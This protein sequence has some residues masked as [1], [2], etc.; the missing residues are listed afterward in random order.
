MA[1]ITKEYLIKSV[2]S[3][4]GIG[5]FISDTEKAKIVAKEL[6]LSLSSSAKVVEHSVT[7]SFNKAGQQVKSFSTTFEDFGRRT[8]ISFKTVAGVVQ[9]S[10]LSM[11]K[12]ISNFSAT[13]GQKVL[14]LNQ[15]LDGLAAKL[16]TL[17]SLNRTFSQTF[18]A[19]F[20]NASEIVQNQPEKLS[21]KTITFEGKQSLVPVQQL[22]TVVKTADGDFQK[23]N[24]TIVTLPNGVKQI[25]RSMSDVSAS[26]KKAAL[27]AETLTNASK[28]V[29]L[30]VTKVALS[31]EQAEKGARFFSSGMSRA[32]LLTDLSSKSINR[33]GSE[34]LRTTA[35]FNDNGKKV[36]TV[37]DSM[38]SSTKKVSQS[39][40]EFKEKT[41]A[42]GIDLG[43]LISRAAVTIPVWFA[44]RSAIMG[45]FTGIRDGITNLV[46]F[47]AALQ[48]VKR[49]LIGTPQQITSD[50]EKMRKVITEFSLQTGKPVEEIA[51]AVK[52]FATIGFNFEDSLQGGLD[53][54]KLSILL[55]G[56]AGQSAEAF[57]VALKL[58]MKTG[59]DAPPVQQQIAEAFALTAELAK[60]NKDKLSDLSQALGTVAGSASVAKLSFKETITLL[61]TLASAGKGGANGAT[62]LSSALSNLLTKLPQVSKSFGVQFIPGADSAFST[63]TKILDVATALSKTPAG[64]AQVFEKLGEVFGG[65]R[66][67]KLT[68]AL[69]AANAA[70]KENLKVTGDVARFN[71]G[72]TTVLDSESGQ[73]D[74][75]TNSVRETGKAFVTSLV[76][77]GNFKGALTS[78]NQIVTSL[79][80]TLKIIGGSFNAVFTSATGTLAGLG[81]LGASLTKANA[82]LEAMPALLSRVKVGLLALNAGTIA[83]LAIA[84]GVLVDKLSKGPDL[85]GLE[86]KFQATQVK[87]SSAL[88]GELPKVELEKFKVDFKN[89]KAILDVTTPIDIINKA[90]EK[91]LSSEE[92][93]AKVEAGETTLKANLALEAQLVEGATAKLEN[94]LAEL[95]ARLKAKGATDIELALLDV[96][97]LKSQ[98]EALNAE[99]IKDAQSKIRISTFE[100]ERSIQDALIKAVED[101]AKAEGASNLE[102]I[103][104]GIELEKSLGIERTGMELLTQQLSLQKALTEETK[105]T[106]EERLKE[107]SSLIKKTPVTGIAG[108]FKEQGLNNKEDAL[109]RRAEAKGISE[110]QINRILNPE[111]QISKGNTLLDELQRGLANPMTQ[112]MGSLEIAIS[113]LTQTILQQETRSLEVGVPRFGGGVRGTGNSLM[114]SES[115]KRRFDNQ[116]P[117]SVTVDVGGINVTVSG[118]GNADDIAQR[119]AKTVEEMISSNMVKPGTKANIAFTQVMHKA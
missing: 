87:L 66:G 14:T 94:D 3:S 107:L 4:I 112:S 114:L 76:G 40:G 34:F 47:D 51:S 15:P 59:K 22:S 44:L 6:G 26:F 55:F 74:I 110:E 79:N 86:D 77:A 81:I 64:E 65:Q 78:L 116:G 85:S 33:N 30:A 98:G 62:L 96:Q 119:V 49:N 56:E 108:F 32:A 102:A 50:F 63:L 9:A 115:D 39:F 58:L 109:R 19:S 88:R 70:L 11:S 24:Q 13:V 1:N 80:P 117:S 53:A 68:S 45:V 52:E 41:E 97:F 36:T 10:S 84:F 90:L 23:L 111:S 29:S 54:T 103:N 8:S 18:G 60:T 91:A 71:Q 72:V 104:R 37:F 101:G 105:K 38:G 16:T 20:K 82:L 67:V 21:Q 106:K 12:D 83:G 89:G 5:K 118:A 69:T 25:S 73:Y 61:L 92:V 27:D 113:S 35:I 28:N 99:K 2:Y 17:T 75:L 42:A 7:T 95:K 57:A 93:K 46:S 31:A 100:K 43:K 48:K